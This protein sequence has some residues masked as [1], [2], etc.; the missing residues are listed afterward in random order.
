MTH[1]NS[2]DDSSEVGIDT[3]KASETE[4]QSD[5]KAVQRAFAMNKKVQILS[6]FGSC[7]A[8]VVPL[9]TFILKNTLVPLVFLGFCILKFKGTILYYKGDIIIPI[10]G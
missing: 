7:D 10:N 6:Y 9:F 4:R 8:F 2:R 1:L 5:A 3:M